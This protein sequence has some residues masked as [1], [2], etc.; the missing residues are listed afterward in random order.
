MNVLGKETSTYDYFHRR[1]FNKCS[2][3]VGFLRKTFDAKYQNVKNSKIEE[4]RF[5]ILVL[6]VFGASPPKSSL[7]ST[8]NQRG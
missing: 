2:P 1:T 7:I 5:I 8:D 3:K 6:H 4:N